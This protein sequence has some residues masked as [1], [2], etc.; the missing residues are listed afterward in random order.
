MEIYG[1]KQT[2]NFEAVLHKNIGELGTFSGPVS[3]LWPQHRLHT[4]QPVPASCSRTCRIMSTPHSRQPI[5]LPGAN[6]CTLLVTCR[7]YSSYCYTL[8]HLR[9]KGN[10][11]P[12]GGHTGVFA[13]QFKLKAIPGPVQDYYRSISTYETWSEVIDEIYESVESVEPWLTGNARG[14]STAF[15]CLYKLC[16]MQL[17][18]KN[19]SDTLSHPDSPFIR[20]VRP[21]SLLPVLLHPER[22]A[23]HF[24]LR[25]RTYDLQA[26]P[27]VS[28]HAFMLSSALPRFSAGPA[29]LQW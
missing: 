3:R 29:H 9:Q 7:L 1:N 16:S 18:R 28:Q 2:F 21:M 11:S 15:C 22:H 14:P 25:A 12:H 10:A 6:Y 5:G 27:W 13:C 24:C 19:I 20:A 17:T 4:R 8:R 26:F 23:S